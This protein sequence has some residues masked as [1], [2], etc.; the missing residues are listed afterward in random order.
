[1]APFRRQTRRRG[2]QSESGAA[3]IV[4]LLFLT[5]GSLLVVSLGNLSGTNLLN[6]SVIQAQRNVEYAADAGIDGAIHSIRYHGGCQSFPKSGSLQISGYYIFV[7]CTGTPMAGAKVSGTTLTAPSGAS[8]TP[9]DVGQSVSDANLPGGFSTIQTYVNSTT[10]TMADSASATDSNAVVG[11]PFERLDL[12]LACVST[13]SSI[14][15]CPASQAVI[16][17]VVDF[18]DVDHNGNPTTG[19]NMTILSWDVNTANG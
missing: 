9:A 19:Y 13:S 16:T 5:I 14:N 15:S 3:L 10:A 17:A 18:Q 1:M 11:N 4:A 2:P 12:L 8:F 6:T 7:S